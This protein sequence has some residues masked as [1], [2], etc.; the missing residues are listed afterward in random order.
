MFRRKKSQLGPYE[1]AR[2]EDKLVLAALVDAGA[3]LTEPRYVLHFI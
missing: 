1:S 3:T 2:A